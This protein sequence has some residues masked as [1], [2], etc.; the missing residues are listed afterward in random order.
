VSGER[1]LRG[2]L[3]EG[4]ETTISRSTPIPPP[5]L[6]DRTG[7]RM[8][9][10]G[11]NGDVAKNVMARACKAA[12]I[13]H[14]SPHSLRHRRISIWHHEGIP[15]RVLAERAGHARAS[16]SL[17]VYSHVQPPGEAAAE[18]LQTLI[19]ESKEGP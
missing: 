12:S 9:F 1:F 15:A 13:P 6:E 8:V 18:T 4:L 19:D 16:M 3:G 5:L 14:Y 7:E 17:D 10:P 2:N 11:F